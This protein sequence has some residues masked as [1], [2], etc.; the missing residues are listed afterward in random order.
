MVKYKPASIKFYTCLSCIGILIGLTV[1]A[2]KVD[3]SQSNANNVTSE[4]VA[5]AQTKQENEASDHDSSSLETISSKFEE[6]K[7]SS[8]DQD[9]DMP[10]SSSDS[11]T[12]SD[13]SSESSSSSASSEESSSSSSSSESSSS[14]SSQSSSSSPASSEDNS[15]TESDNITPPANSSSG[16]GSPSSSADSIVDA[17]TRSDDNDEQKSQASSSKVS[18]NSDQASSVSQK[19]EVQKITDT[20][21]KAQVLAAR[22]VRS[23]NDSSSGDNIKGNDQANTNVVDFTNATTAYAPPSSTVLKDDS[24]FTLNS[25]LYFAAVFVI[26]LI[27]TLYGEIQDSRKYKIEDYSKKNRKK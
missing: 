11:S 23:S 15:S 5:R 14:S 25:F 12:S 4:K 3:A 1:V 18:S 9:S 26:I 13:S 27:Y 17:P 20:Y 21:S 19:D 6:T 22:N 2:P 10:S 7:S 16:D 8:D 24:H